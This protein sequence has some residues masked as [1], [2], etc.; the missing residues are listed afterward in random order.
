[1]PVLIFILV[2]VG[3]NLWLGLAAMCFALM[4]E[5]L[6][7]RRNMKVKASITDTILKGKNND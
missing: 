6:N 7:K 1:M 5:D 2:W 3:T 4:I